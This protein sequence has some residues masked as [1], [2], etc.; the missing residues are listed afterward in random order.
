MKYLILLVAVVLAGA[1]GWVLSARLSGPSIEERA[2]RIEDQ[3]RRVAKLATAEGQYVRMYRYVDE[4][5]T[6]LFR[7]TDK[8]VVIQA[9]A[10]VVMGFDLEGVTVT[11]DREARE[12]VVEGWPPPEEIAFEFDTELFDV[13]EGLLVDVDKDD[14]NSVRRGA[15][16]RMRER[17]DYERLRRESYAQAAE[18]LEIVRAELTGSGYVLR[19]EGW[20]DELA[21]ASG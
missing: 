6:S 5:S 21:A 18:L 9:Q 7:F 2:V 16:K 13:S 17:I 10:R 20:P 8:R 14:L 1:L 19:V 4:G 15:R 11:V 12:L 3:V